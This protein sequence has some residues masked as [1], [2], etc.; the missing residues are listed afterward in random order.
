MKVSTREEIARVLASNLKRLREEK[1]MT[2]EEL[3]KKAGL[4]KEICQRIEDES[5]IPRMSTVARIVAALGCTYDDLLPISSLTGPEPINPGEIKIFR[6]SQQA[7]VKKGRKAIDEIV[8]RGVVK[9][10]ACAP[11]YAIVNG[12]P[13][14]DD[15][16]L[17]DGDIISFESGKNPLSTHS[18][19]KNHPH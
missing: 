4:D 13:V 10:V 3:A 11:V 12:E 15:Y 16:V 19:T 9:E 2:S 5:E 8:F 14:Q 7:V 6:G 18:Y 1:G 17:K